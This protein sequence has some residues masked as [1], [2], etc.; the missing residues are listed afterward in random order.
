MADR[1]A[2]FLLRVQ[3]QSEAHPEL[4][5]GW[6]RAFDF[7]QWDY[8]GSNADA[9]WGAWSIEVGWTQAWIPTVLALRE[10]KLNLWD[11]S[12]GSQVGKHFEKCRRLMLG[13]EPYVKMQTRTVRHAATGKPARLAASPDPRY[14]ACGAASLTDGLL[15]SA[16]HADPQWLGLLGKDLEATI[17]LGAA[18]EIRKLGASFLQ[19]HGVGIFLPKQ[20]EFSVSDDGKNF[21][22][23]G[24]AEPAPPPRNLT[25]KTEVL[26]IS[27]LQA[28]A[29]Y[30]RVR[31]VNY[32]AIPTWVTPQ[33][34]PAWLFVD[35]VLV[36]P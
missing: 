16:D 12:K 30:V 10:L 34:L 26:S 5:G 20:V 18:T 8:W 32:G 7:R 27:S 28:K 19:S 24:T 31:A 25:P 23:V 29:R 9:G 4:D 36:A 21:R 2:E 11:L 1:L 33:T 14:P 35:E 22:I 6:F 13:D 15:G 3:V 17:D